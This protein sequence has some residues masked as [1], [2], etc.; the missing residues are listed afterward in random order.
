VTGGYVAEV[1]AS[2][3]IFVHGMNHQEYLP[4]WWFQAFFIFTPTW[5]D[6]PILVIFFRWVETTN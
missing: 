1:S 5:G 6:D 3:Y 2:L 4:K